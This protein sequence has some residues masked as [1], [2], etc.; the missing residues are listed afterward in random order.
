MEKKK[1]KLSLAAAVCITI[2]VIL[3]IALGCMYYVT[4]HKNNEQEAATIEENVIN[5]NNIPEE[6]TKKSEILTSSEIQKILGPE[7]AIF[8]IEDIE[9]SGDEYII[10]AYMLEKEYRIVT[11]AE[12][13]KL[14]NGGEIEFRK[15]KWKKDDSSE[16]K[17]EDYI[18]IK[19]GESRLAL[20]Y[21][22]GKGAIYKYFALVVIQ[23]FASG[24]IVDMLSENVFC[25]CCVEQGG[26]NR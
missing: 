22:E 11:K 5:V 13:E 19:S 3:I 25:I 15:L 21:K 26:G 16:F 9:K 24:F 10:T 4:K 20:D 1:I 14:L 2:I 7:D 8:C 6:T 23:M 18:I 12:Y 17:N